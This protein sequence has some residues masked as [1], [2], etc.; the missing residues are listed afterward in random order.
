MFIQK[1]MF[2]LMAPVVL[3]GC[4]QTTAQPLP[5]IPVPQ[6]MEAQQGV[7][8]ATTAT[9][10]APKQLD[11]EIE[12]AVAYLNGHFKARLGKALIVESGKPAGS[13]A[14]SIEI[15]GAA[16]AP[17]AYQL[18][19]GTKGIVLKG[20]SA[21]GVFYGVQT[22]IQLFPD[23]EGELAIPAV[24]IEDHPAFPYRGMHLDVGRHFFPVSF[25]KQYIDMLSR[26]KMNRFHWH[27]TED[28]GWRI[29]IKRY[30]RLQEIAA[31]RDE[32]L[33]GHYNDIPQT[34][35]GTRYGGFY[36][37]DEIREVVEYARRR[38][39]TIIPEIE[40]PGHAQAAIAAYP[41]LGCTGRPVKVATKWGVFDD[42]FC[43]SETTFEFLENVLKEVMDLFPGEY[44]HIGGDECPKT[45]WIDSPVAREVIQREG[46]KDEYELQSY[47]IRRIEKFLN[48]NGRQIIG[49]DEILEGGIAPNATIMSWRGMEG[50]IEAARQ[51]HKVIMTPTSHC[52]L[53]YYQAINP[54][55][56]LAIGGYL[57]LEK[58]YS[59][60]PGPEALKGDA[61]K[62]VIGAQGNVWTEY[63]QDEKKVQYMVYPR[64]QALAEVVWSGEAKKDFPGFI[65][66]LVVHLERLNRE[67]VNFANHLFDVK[68][69]VIAGQGKEVRVRW[70]NLA[71]KG[72]MHILQGTGTPGP[73]DEKASGDVTL[74]NPGWYQAQTVLDGKPVGQS[75][76]IFYVP[77]KA[78][79]KVIKLAKAPAPQYSAAGPASAINGVLGSDER[80]GDA[81]W[82]GFEGSDFDA[83]ID[84]G[85][86]TAVRKVNFRFFNAPGQWIYPPKAI[87][88]SMSDQ[89]D[90]FDGGIS[91]TINV[92]R[93]GDI[94]LRHIMLVN[95]SGRYMR[96]HVENYG[97][98]PA[99]KPGTGHKAWLFIDELIVE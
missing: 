71:N 35:D 37:Q 24:R 17:E 32:T 40:L 79:G 90:K 70:S 51:S 14:I 13:K 2:V 80:Y 18:T 50:G 5:V 27:L 20:G 38:F 29:E 1:L 19:V 16:L 96:V 69:E 68:G 26:Y 99:N 87:H 91:A 89:P 84:F 46:L 44:I 42:V 25:I 6:R 45:Q 9:V 41:E 33:K 73:Y 82:Q 75:A 43:P 39:V 98:I 63:M 4:R 61:A 66:R 23:A 52:Y 86:S 57:P 67:G 11:E 55:E 92:T 58:V 65:K 8:V 78:A 49:W 62:F 94:I 95:G 88:I 85:A 3:M 47:F 30:P 76:A 74:T 59:F 36:T 60:N 28:Q 77:H 48:A 83:V 93:P 7:F 64:M 97:E 81:E 31:F 72:D 12:W 34:Y 15:D 56:P 53:D 21:A 22:L 54:N 10:I